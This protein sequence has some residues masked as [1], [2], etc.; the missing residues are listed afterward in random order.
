[1][2][3]ISKLAVPLAVLAQVG[4]AEGAC[5]RA[6]LIDT[7]K[8]VAM[9]GAAAEARTTLNGEVVAADTAWGLGASD[10]HVHNAYADE[11]TGQVMVVGT[12]TGADGAPAIFGL[13]AKVAEGTVVEAE[14]MVTKDGEASLFPREIPVATDPQF[15]DIVPEGQR[16]S[17]ETMIQLANT[18]FDGIE[19]TEGSDLA[20]TEGCNRVENGIQMTH[21]KRF[22]DMHCNTMSLFSYIPRVEQRRFPIIDEERGVV[23]AI[24]M[25]QIPEADIVRVRDGKEVVRHY[26]PRS[27]YLFEAFKVVDGKVAQIEAT[28]RDLAFEQVIDWPN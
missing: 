7:A 19:K 20:I 10:V 15:G 26:D 23:V 18:Y 9:G 5:D 28:M 6:C 4:L 3:G 12:G 1:M 13:R 21:S 27:L 25:F 17:P 22:P 11:D 8:A 16:S 14:W 24:V 2:R